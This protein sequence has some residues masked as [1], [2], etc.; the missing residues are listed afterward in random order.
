MSRASERRLKR[1]REEDEKLQ[2]QIRTGQV[3]YERY[4]ER[5]KK[6][7][8]P[9]RVNMAE[10]PE[11]ELEDRQDTIERATVV[12]R[13]MLP[14]LLNKLSRIKDP[15]NPNQITHKITVLLLYGIL[16][17]VYQTGS[18]RETNRTMNRIYFENMKAMFPELESLPHADTLA[19]LLEKI[20]VSEIQECMVELLKD[21][22]KRKKFKNYLLKKNYLIAIDGT[23]KFYRNYQWDEKCL[24]RNVGKEEAKT[25][26]H[27]VYVLESVLIL[28]NG[29]TLPLYS[30]F[31]DNEDWVKGETKQD[32]E[33][34]AFYR[35]AEKIK[36]LFRNSHITIVVDGLYACGPVIKTCLQN[37]WNYMIVL[38]EDCL[39]TV[40]ADAKG[41]MKLELENSLHVKW[42]DRD[43]EYR[44]ANHV[45]YEY[46]DNKKTRYLMLH[47]V[48]CHETW[49]EDHNR[50]TGKI[51][52][53][54]TRYA[55]LSSKPLSKSNVF[56]RC[57][58]I[59][60]YRW[61]IENNIL[62]EKHH[63]YNYEHCY[64]YTWN[65]MEGY[66]Y[67]MKIGR[68]LNVL[69]VNSELLA[70]KVEALGVQGFIKFLKMACT[71]C[72]LDAERIREAVGRKRQW[73]LVPIE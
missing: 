6:P 40:W 43:Q 47:V 58:K 48:T 2:E 10:S 53:K 13:Q 55:W 32:C 5:K 62:A 3:R 46:K 71:G 65:A 68:L 59:G 41:L 18:R 22:I 15:R 24:E 12:Y 29:I 57:T 19:R 39:K 34:K 33:R 14:S 52:Q 69:A 26:Q 28:N 38:K 51:E 27:Y 23:Q 35:L 44:W 60:R 50:S 9:N 56:E 54:E 45:E 16:I 61:G 70:E 49:L 7:A 4:E 1:Q 20:D 63:G 37:K 11:E 72:V 21:L 31:L 36:K 66:H 64:S 73:R 17:F 42:G 25:T 67:L 8:M 30:L